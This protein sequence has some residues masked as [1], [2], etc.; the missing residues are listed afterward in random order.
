MFF[1]KKISFILPLLLSLFVLGGASIVSAQ[2]DINSLT[3]QVGTAS[4]FDVKQVTETTLSETIGRIIR[5]ALSLIGTGFFALTIY[6]GFLWM[7]AQG[8]D[9]QVEKAMGII[10]TATVGLLVTL[11]AYGLTVYIVGAIA[12]TSGKPS[13]GTVG[14]D[15]GN[16]GF[17]SSFGKTCT[18]KDSWWK[19]VF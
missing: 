9:E 11:A 2:P 3:E 18:G 8:S 6:A 4:G 12:L 19:C 17:W 16:G 10:K 15:Y 14:T 5:I 13:T 1:L 7:T